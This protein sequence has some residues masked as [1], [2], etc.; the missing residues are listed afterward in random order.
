MDIYLLLHHPTHQPTPH[1]VYTYVLCRLARA[2]FWRSLQLPQ[3]APG[4]EDSGVKAP[5]PQSSDEAAPLR[6]S[7]EDQHSKGQV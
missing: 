7:A 1:L 5:C 2:I 3:A 6:P 4:G